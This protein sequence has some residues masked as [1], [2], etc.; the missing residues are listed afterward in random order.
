MSKREIL[1]RFRLS[2]TADGWA[3][4][5]APKRKY[6][7]SKIFET[8]NDDLYFSRGPRGEEPKDW[9]FNMAI[10]VSQDARVVCVYCEVGW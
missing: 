6:V 10:H 1:D 2:M 8:G 4:G 7:L 5:S 9:F 3:L